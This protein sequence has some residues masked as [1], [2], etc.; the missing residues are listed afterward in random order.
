MSQNIEAPSRFDELSALF[1]DANTLETPKIVDCKLSGGTETQC[2]SITTGPAPANHKTGPYCPRTIS[3]TAEQAGTWFVNEKLYDVDGKFIEQLGVI[4]NDNEWQMFDAATGKVTLAEGQLGCDVA[5]DP[6]SAPDYKNYCVECE[7]KYLDPN[8]GQ[9]FVFPL[10]P[11][12]TTG[13]PSRIGPHT[14]IGLAFN[15][16]KLDAPAPLDLILG[17]HTLGLFDACVGHVNPTTGY[18]YHGLVGCEPN[19]TAGAANHSPL[20]AVAMD[21]F[22]IYAKLDDGEAGSLDECG[23]HVVGGLGYHYHVEAAGTNQFIGCFKAE[24]GCTLDNSSA[25]CDA[26][27]QERRGPRGR[28]PEGAGP[29]GPRPDGPRPDGP[30]PD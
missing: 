1:D 10:E 4:Y 29:G 13:N 6:N 19:K 12:L 28:G 5:G 21:G 8:A 24:S 20:V 26:S 27:V 17:S 23:G 11:V 3:D 7:V 15:G 16:V 30:R 14:G 25:T 9:T 22:D 18:H 2:F